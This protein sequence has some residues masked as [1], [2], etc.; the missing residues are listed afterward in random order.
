M[1][2]LIGF[3]FHISGYAIQF[4]LIPDSSLT[5]VPIETDHIDPFGKLSPISYELAKVSPQPLSFQMIFSGDLPKE[6]IINADLMEGALKNAKIYRVVTVAFTKVPFLYKY[7]ILIFIMFVSNSV[8]TPGY[9]LQQ[10]CHLIHSLLV[11]NINA[12]NKLIV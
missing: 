2:N 4:H 12:R 11:R 3:I 9:Y 1:N 6:I 5:D 7:K 10:A 8:K